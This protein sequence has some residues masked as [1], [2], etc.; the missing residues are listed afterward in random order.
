[1]TRAA[2]DLMAERERL[3]NEH[4]IA[5]LLVSAQ[6]SLECAINGRFWPT[7]S[8]RERLVRAGALILAE[9]ERMDRERSEAGDG[10]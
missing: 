10:K 1:M 3:D 8:R 6:F 5:D 9:I 2:E 4:T 7:P